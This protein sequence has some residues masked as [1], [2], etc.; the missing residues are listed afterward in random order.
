M[1]PWKK[2]DRERSCT[3]E[4]NSFTLLHLK[5]AVLEQRP[6]LVTVCESLHREHILSHSLHSREPAAKQELP[7][8]VCLL[9][10]SD[11]PLDIC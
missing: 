9:K 3:N 4:S 1:I 10:G 5:V 2:R 7:F 11:G 6:I 8:V